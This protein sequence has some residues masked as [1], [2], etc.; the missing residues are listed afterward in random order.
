[1]LSSAVKKANT[2][3]EL[4]NVEDFK[5]AIKAYGDACGLLQQAMTR[6][7]DDEI[8]LDSIVSTPRLSIWIGTTH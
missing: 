2:A 6:T 8:L 4:D 1:M 3:V 5:G 7:S